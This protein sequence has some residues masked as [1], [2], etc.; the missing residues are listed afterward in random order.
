MVI[1]AKLRFKA[2]AL[3]AK[4]TYR[5]IVFEFGEFVENREGRRRMALAS[6]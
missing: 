1:V 4:E 3:N 5:H 6:K 2:C